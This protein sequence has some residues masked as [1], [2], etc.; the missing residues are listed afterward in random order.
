V[1]KTREDLS[2]PA[3]DLMDA[4]VVYWRGGGVADQVWHERVRQI[5]KWGLQERPN[6][7]DADL[8]KPR[9]LEVKEQYEFALKH[10]GLTWVHIL[11]EEVYEAFA[12]ED[13][14]KLKVEL[15]QVMAV[16]ASWLQDLELNPRT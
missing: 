3:A 2:G 10:D 6:G 11:R 1:A 4:G 8:W 16:A 5:N 7:T 14:E 9:E 12:E 13:V 15:V